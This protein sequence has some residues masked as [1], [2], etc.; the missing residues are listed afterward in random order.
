MGEPY[1]PRTSFVL[2]RTQVLSS[3]TNPTPSSPAQPF[4]NVQATPTGASSGTTALRQLTAL[5]IPGPS[6]GPPTALSFK[7]ARSTYTPVSRSPLTVIPPPLPTATSHR[8]PSAAA[9][10]SPVKPTP[11]SQD[12]PMTI[13]SSLSLTVAT[14]ASQAR[15]SSSV[16]PQTPEPPPQKATSTGAALTSS[17]TLTAGGIASSPPSTAHTPST[18][19]LVRWSGLHPGDS[20]IENRSSVADSALAI[21]KVQAPNPG[22]QQAESEAAPVKGKKQNW[23]QKIRKYFWD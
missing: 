7:T 18:N 10:P 12:P 2:T 17:S 1:I 20:Q 16:V 8:R 23:F 13:L 21:S 22:Q 4:S 3:P 15:P 14:F 5:Q 19:N 6:L 11:I 9:P